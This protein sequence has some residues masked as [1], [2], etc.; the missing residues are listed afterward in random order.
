MKKTRREFLKASTVSAVGLWSSQTFANESLQESSLDPSLINHDLLS[1]EAHRSADFSGVKK[2]IEFGDGVLP[3]L[4]GNYIRVA[5]GTKSVGDQYYQHFFDGDAYVYNL[6]FSDE[7]LTLQAKFINTPE[8]VREQRRGRQIYS[9]FG[10]T[11]PGIIKLKK[12]SPSINIIPW[13][14][15]LLCLSDTSAPT[16]IDSSDF[17]YV[18]EY[19][20]SRTLKTNITFTAHPKRDPRTNLLYAYGITRS[21]S[22]ELEIYEIDPKTDRSKKLH[23]Y[24]LDFIP[25]V[26][27]MI[28]TENYILVFAPPMKISITKMLLQQKSYAESL[29]ALSGL[30][31]QLYV[32]PKNDREK[33]F[34]IET[35]HSFSFHHGNAYEE[36]EFLNITTFASPDPSIFDYLMTWNQLS[37]AKV[38]SLSQLREWT[39]DLNK[40]QFVEETILY[41]G[42]DFPRLNENYMGVKNRY[43][44]SVGQNSRP[45]L[46]EE[47]QITFGVLGDRHETLFNENYDGDLLAFKQIVK[48]DLENRSFKRKD[49]PIHQTI[50]EALFVSSANAIEE[51]DGYLLYMGYDRER[52]ESFFD[53][54]NAKTFDLKNRFWMGCYLPMG[55]HANFH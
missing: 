5:P 22:P 14:D 48:Y 44:Y 24:K 2:I 23:S 41:E 11:A 45:V 4:R 29:E 32:F 42:C 3:P 36:G 9:E 47:P 20:F 30:S 34:T 13:E 40:K 38:T 12:N 52:K 10:T 16:A 21:L 50:G 43:L 7:A 1:L 39:I 8:R 25:L 26:H 37:P 53:V 27:D 15:S 19:D 46:N 28:V 35:P 55:F 18:G 6:N 51:D 54:L 17:S 49:F 33:P 31:S